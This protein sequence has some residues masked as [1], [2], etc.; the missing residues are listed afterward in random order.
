LRRSSM[1]TEAKTPRLYWAT[2][3]L[4]LVIGIIYL[5]GFSVGGRQLDGAIAL[6]VMVVFSVIIALVGFRSETVRG[7]LDHRDERITAIDLR[8]TAAAALAMCIAV[9]IGFVIQVAEGHDANAY[10]VI[11]VV[12]GLAYVAAVVY[13]R[14]RT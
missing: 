9:L 11:G 10:V 1:R 8:A 6:G 12:G 3:I 5:I 2:P 4:G 7:L 13:F 14:I